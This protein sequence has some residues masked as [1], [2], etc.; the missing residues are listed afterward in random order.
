M[1]TADVRREL[2][3]IAADAPPNP[4]SYPRTYVVR[5]GRTDG[6]LDLDPPPDAADKLKSISGAEVWGPP[7]MSTQALPG[8]RVVVI[9][10]DA[11]FARAVVIGFEPLSA[12]RHP[13]VSLDADAV[14]LG[15]ADAPAA[16]EGG[17]YT[18]GSASGVLTFVPATPPFDIPS[19]VKV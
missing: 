12:G 8:D 6:K 17:T 18:L 1:S 4:Y 15:G 13:R 11:H 9:F 10:R 2:L 3:A 7:G 19:R 5:N 16:R 14:K